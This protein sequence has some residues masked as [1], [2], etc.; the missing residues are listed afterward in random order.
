MKRK[1][2][3]ILF[4]F[5][6]ERSKNSRYRERPDF[7]L[8]LFHY[9]LKRGFTYRGAGAGSGQ[10]NI[11]LQPNIYHHRGHHACFRDQRQHLGPLTAVGNTTPQL[12]RG[13][14]LWEIVRGSFLGKPALLLPRVPNSVCWALV[15]GTVWASLIQTLLLSRHSQSKAE[16]DMINTVRGAIQPWLQRQKR[17]KRL[18]PTKERESGKVL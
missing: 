11:G 18:M 6:W 5:V 15:S 1:E 4:F 14:A 12:S 8:G 2:N 9:M 10:I 3:K 17:E 13:H 16:A 7:S